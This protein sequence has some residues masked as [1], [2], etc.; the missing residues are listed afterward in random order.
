MRATCPSPGLE[1]AKRFATEEA[2]EAYL[3]R[4]RWPEGFRCP[5]CRHA[6]CF[7]LSRRPLYQCA[8]CRHQASVTAGTVFHKSLL[9]LPVWFRAIFLVT[10]GEQG[11]SSL[12]LQRE[13]DLGSYRTA[14]LLQ[15]K[16]RRSLRE[17]SAFPLRDLVQSTSAVDPRARR[18]SRVRAT[19]P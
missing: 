11:I 15:R 7:R 4:W 9:P 13:L 6:K 16:I 17:G 2:C 5:R 19:A 3:F 12:R 8:R 10:R 14:W 1:L 18:R